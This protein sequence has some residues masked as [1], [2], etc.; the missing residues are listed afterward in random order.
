MTRRP[1]LLLA[2]LLATAPAVG[3][4]Q[5][6]GSLQWVGT[7]SSFSSTFQNYST[8]STVTGYAGAAY[9]ANASLPGT[10]PWY[11]QASNGF[12]PAVDILCIDFL[13]SALTTTYPAYFTNLAYDDLT[14][15]RGTS[16][17]DYQRVAWL[18]TQMEVLPFTNAGRQQRAEVHAAI[19]RIMAGQPQYARANVSGGSFAGS[20]AQISSW[21][22]LANANYATVNLSQ[23]TVVTAMCVDNAGHSGS[24]F[25]LPDNCGQEF[26]V[27][28]ATVTPEPGTMLML[29]TGLMAIVGAGVVGRGG[30]AA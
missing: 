11:L 27:R 5:T 2:A 19:W 29:A 23:F 26:L 14:V 22:S 18:S 16:L 13:H 9:R 4:A 7:G 17:A 24:G 8:S 15:T 25:N 1:A 3:H 30:F 28:D 21:V 20:D 12:G 6:L 10:A